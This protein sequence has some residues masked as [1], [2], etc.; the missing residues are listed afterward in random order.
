MSDNGRG[1]LGNWDA[2]GAEI[3]DALVQAVENAVREHKRA[4]RPVIVW[5]RDRDEIV[6]LA[7]DQIVVNDEPVA[8]AKR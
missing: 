1:I 4:G 3:R 8:S 6:S 2:T 7:P 5:D